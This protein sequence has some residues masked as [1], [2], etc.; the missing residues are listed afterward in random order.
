MKKKDECEI[1]PDGTFSPLESE[2]GYRIVAPV[3]GVDV[4]KDILHGCILFKN[5]K[6]K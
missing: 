4:H 1:N 2:E 6:G 3:I 5:K